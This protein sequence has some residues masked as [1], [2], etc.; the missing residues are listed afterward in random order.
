MRE[1]S[2]QAAFMQALEL[3]KELVPECKEVGGKNRHG[4]ASCQSVLQ[5][6][7]L[8]ATQPKAAR[9]SNKIKALEVPAMRDD[10]QGPSTPAV[11]DLVL[12]L[13]LGPCNPEGKLVCI[14][15]SFSICMAKDV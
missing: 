3:A 4:G 10:H 12:R 6:H 8:G 11:A 14:A 9:L 13:E 15:F 1:D 7:L 5:P 2:P